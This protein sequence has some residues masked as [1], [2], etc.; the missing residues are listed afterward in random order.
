MPVC[1][2]ARQQFPAGNDYHVSSGLSSPGVDEPAAPFAVC[3]SRQGGILPGNSGFDMSSLMPFIEADNLLWFTSLSP[4][5]FAERHPVDCRKAS[6]ERHPVDCR[7]A[8]AASHPVDCGL[9]AAP[10]RVGRRGGWRKQ[11]GEYEAS[12]QGH[13]KRYC[14]PCRGHA[15]TAQPSFYVLFH[16][17]LAPGFIVDVFEFCFL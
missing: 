8:S 12:Q 14:P 7:K 5:A 9:P 15:A 4:P 16:R 1:I 2:D 11:E 10:T 6:A 17:T 3:D 13:C